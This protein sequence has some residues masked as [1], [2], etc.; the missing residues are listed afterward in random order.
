[1]LN[2]KISLFIIGY[3]MSLMEKKD[4]LITIKIQVLKR[5]ILKKKN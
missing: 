5:K 4:N 1:M 2:S 3:E